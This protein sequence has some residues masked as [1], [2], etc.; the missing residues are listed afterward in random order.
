MNFRYGSA[1]GKPVPEAY[2]TLLLDA[3][4]GDPTLF[5]RHDFV[6][7]SWALI[8]PVH[9]MWEASGLE[10]I[11]TYEAGEWGPPEADHLIQADGRRWRTL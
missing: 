7:N 5:A 2:E 1:F 11:P 8:T 6:E 4:L 9:Q 10:S 3:L